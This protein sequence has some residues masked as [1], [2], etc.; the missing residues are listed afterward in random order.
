MDG[1]TND[2]G[3]EMTRPDSTRTW[4]SE[5]WSW[6]F[7]HLCMLADPKDIMHQAESKLL[8]K[9]SLNDRMNVYYSHQ[10]VSSVRQGLSSVYLFIITTWLRA[11]HTRQVHIFSLPQQIVIEFLLHAMPVP[12]VP[13]S[14]NSEQDTFL[15]FKERTV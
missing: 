13:T 8:H 9:L 4:S 10:T 6:H 7:P 12:Y 3:G 5:S 2:Q 1:D 15:F 14:I 11:C